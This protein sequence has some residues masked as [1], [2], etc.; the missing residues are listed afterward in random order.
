MAFGAVS[1]PRDGL[2][3]EKADANPRK[4]GVFRKLSIIIRYLGLRG[5]ETGIRTL[6]GVAP[7]TV[8]E[9]API[10]HSGTSPR[11]VSLSTTGGV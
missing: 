5:G 9:T 11:C 10:D 6:G 2:W 3:Q 4:H 7:T 1:S 8:F